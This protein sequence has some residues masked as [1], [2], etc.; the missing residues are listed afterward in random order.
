MRHIFG[1]SGQSLAGAPL[2][3]STA[4]SVWKYLRDRDRTI[5]ALQL[6]ANALTGALRKDQATRESLARQ[7]AER[8]PA[9]A[10]S[11]ARST[12]IMKK[13][14]GAKATR[15]PGKRVTDRMAKKHRRSRRP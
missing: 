3:Y 7:I 5:E 6:Q 8:R 4:T 11:P 1:S 12:P 10:N 13:R 2:Q 9:R 15:P 14:K